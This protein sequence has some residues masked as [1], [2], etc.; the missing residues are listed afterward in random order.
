MFQANIKSFIKLLVGLI[1][2]HKKPIKLSRLNFETNYLRIKRYRFTSKTTFSAF[3]VY[4]KI[5]IN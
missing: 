3:S 1:A 4:N 2:V 5:I